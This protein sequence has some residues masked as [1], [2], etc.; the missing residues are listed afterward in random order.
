M[1]DIYERSVLRTIRSYGVA[2]KGWPLLRLHTLNSRFEDIKDKLI[3]SKLISS[4]KVKSA[5]YLASMATA[6]NIALYE[7]K[8]NH[9]AVTQNLDIDLATIKKHL[10]DSRIR[11]H[12]DST[13]RIDL[14]HYDNVVFDLGGVIADESDLD[15]CICDFLDDVLKKGNYAWK[16]YDD[17]SHHLI[18]ELDPRWYDYYWQADM[19]GV[20]R[21]T[22]ERLHEKNIDK[23]RFYPGSRE[24]IAQLASTGKQLFLI[25]GCNSQI[26]DLRL[27]L[28][29]LSQ[30]FY[31]RQITSDCGGEIGD[32][33]PF[34]NTLIQ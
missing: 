14:S 15:V 7:H 18:K 4:L 2:N 10:N 25:T 26:L 31:T 34:F 24:T 11:Y 33:E 3:R 16:T 8:G 27:S 1:F 17:L 21:K 20:P 12:I 19:L 5:D 6:I 28:Y 29:Q 9:K 32:K 13:G 23:V 30:Y 22:I